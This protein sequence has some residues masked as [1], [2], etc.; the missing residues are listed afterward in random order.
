[1]RTLL[2]G[3]WLAVALTG[4]VSTPHYR[5]TKAVNTA[6]TGACLA[7]QLSPCTI[8]SS[9]ADKAKAAEA[10]AAALRSNAQRSSTAAD[11]DAARR[12]SCLTDT[13]PRLPV[14]Q[15]ECA[16]Y[17]KTYSGDQLTVTG[18]ENASPAPATLD[19]AAGHDTLEDAARPN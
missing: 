11:L 15:S 8:E 16:N 5:T 9:E 19:P 12:S 1:L 10:R 7:A 6:L 17:G 2:V 14:S 18:R 3:T 4:C 13:G